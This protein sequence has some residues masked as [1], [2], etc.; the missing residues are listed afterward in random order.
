MNKINFKSILPHLVAVAIFLLITVIFCKPSLESGVVLKQSDISSWNAMSHQSFEYKEK[1]GHFPLW[2][3][4]MFSGMPAYQI[5]LEGTWTPLG[6][7]DTI[8][9]MG[10]PQ[11]MSFF[12]LACICFYFL[13]ICLG[14]RP[15]VSILGAIAFAFCSYSPIIISAGHV[16]KMLALAYAPAVMGA[17][18]LIFRKK[19]L[20]GFSLTALFTALQV[21]QGHQ[22]I[23]YYLFII[24]LLMSISYIIHSIKEK[25]SAHIVKSLG[26]ILVA[27]IIG[28]AANALVLMTTYDYSKESKRGGQLVMEDRASKSDQIKNGK[29][30]G[31]SKEYAFQWSY[32]IAESWSLMFPGVMGYGLHYADRDGET[33]LF[34]KLNEKSN[35]AAFFSESLNVP[36]DQA[37]NYA[38][39][40]SQRVYW[41]EQPFTNG[42]V[43]LGAIICFLFVLGIFILDH[44]QKWWIILASLFGIMMAWGYHFPSFNYF[45]FD[46]FPLYNK[47]RV[48]TMALI[49]PQLL[50]PLMAVLT[51]NSIMDGEKE[52]QWK[53]FRMAVLSTAVVFGAVYMFYNSSD[54]DRENKQRTQAITKAYQDNKSNFQFALQ[55]INQEENLSPETDNKIMEEMMMNLSQNPGID[56]IK[57]SREM[58]SAIRKDRAQ[59]LIDDILRSLIFVI[60]AA[61]VIALFI[62]K[63]VNWAI[64]II[65]MSLLTAIDLLQF[66]MNYLNEKSYA[67]K[68]EYESNEFP[69]TEADN[70][71]LQD[72]DPNFRVMNTRGL[73]EAKTSYHHKSIGGYHPA[74]L[75]IYDDLMAYQF[76]GQPNLAVINMLNTKYV[77]QQQGDKTVASQNPGALGNVWFVKGVQYVN[78]PVEEMKA[79]TNFNPS[80]TAVID[81]QF[82]NS[83]GNFQSAD[84][85]ETIKQTSFDNDAI[86]Y[87][88]NTKA[89]HLAVFSEIYYKDWN[90]YVDGK[91]T[92]IA[93]ANYVLRS[94]I[95]P[96][97]T[98][99]IEFKFEPQSV[100]LGNKLSTTFGWLISILSLVAI[101]LSLRTINAGPTD[102]QTATS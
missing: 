5:A 66:G 36:E 10:L 97:G 44:K 43:Y 14:I 4:N 6:V 80:D 60:L 62:Q 19:Y 78:G 9:Q 59:F 7:I 75:G 56:A 52:N 20:L 98:H 11:P 49:I 26:M 63:K 51:L 92:E 54:F 95:I 91:K 58:V 18:V 71:I 76:N 27:G 46:H 34:P 48:P 47:F 87:S 73:E 83:I 41:G 12:Y 100:S 15:Y 32:G 85:S 84:S 86:T 79:I 38:F 8:I 57:V 88:S 69:L 21:G 90:A 35:T 28:V 99:K 82:Q 74:K 24:L 65:A 17:V 23:S 2:A 68:E 30:E 53:K 89:A 13:C 37:A 3:T 50:F 29:T 39:S 55:Q 67:N 70:Q 72:S 94:M 102:K 101:V 40:A 45:L 81:K 25:Q 31:L 33:H 22:Q 77:I 93:K 96:A 64:M 16:T 61:A 1:N 42:P